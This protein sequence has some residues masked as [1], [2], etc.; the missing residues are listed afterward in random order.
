M[1]AGRHPLVPEVTLGGVAENTLFG[2]PRPGSASERP[3][4]LSSVSPDVR[5][6]RCTDRSRPSEFIGF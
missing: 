1:A 3:R 6:W 5:W 2:A 4:H